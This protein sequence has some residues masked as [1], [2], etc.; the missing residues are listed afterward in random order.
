MALGICL[1]VYG[2]YD[3]SPGVQVLGV[4]ATVA[5]M[6]LAVRTLG[7]PKSLVGIALICALLVL[8]ASA[9]YLLHDYK[10]QSA[11][12]LAANITAD[13]GS[14][15]DAGDKKTCYENRVASLTSNGIPYAFEVIAELHRNDALFRQKCHYNI[16]SIGAA[17]YNL[18][19]SSHTKEFMTSNMSICNYGFY[20]GFMVALLEDT[21]DAMA[22]QDFC[23]DLPPSLVEEWPDVVNQCYH[24][25][26]H[27]LL[28]PNIPAVTHEKDLTWVKT[29]LRSAVPTALNDCAILT[30]G[31]ATYLQNCYSGV[32]HE[33]AML[34]E[35]RGWATD[36]QNP[37]WLCAEM[38]EQYAARCAGNWHRLV[39]RQMQ[40][41]PLT[42]VMTFMQTTYPT[43]P[44]FS[45]SV[46]WRWAFNNAND[47]SS[48]IH[49]ITSCKNVS[50]ELHTYC[51]GGAIASL[52]QRS[53][54]AG[55]EYKVVTQLCSEPALS[56]EELNICISKSY[57]YFKVVY[58][59]TKMRAICHEFDS[60]YHTAC[61][62]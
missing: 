36:L 3:D 39:V 40:S 61:A 34:S 13:C 15:E 12:Q 46:A 7:K 45:A 62:Q 1:I 50:S 41:A 9:S 32:F 59:A 44:F 52:H 18:Y 10:T 38:P 56:E 6:V 20:H 43:N 51:I 26:A 16:H 58:N 4:V 55:E 19:R 27:G 17:A 53:G 31:H 33:A 8:A 47:L 21:G 48:A 22:A 24:G 5:G 42:D 11:T 28:D 35:G 25:I 29:I 57:D 37:L 54:A 14:R 23:N 60:L 2:G 30:N 49:V